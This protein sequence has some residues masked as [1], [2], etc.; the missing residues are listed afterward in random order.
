M[1]GHIPAFK[2]R[3]RRQLWCLFVHHVADRVDVRCAGLEEFVHHDAVRVGFDVCSVKVQ[4]II[5]PPP[6]RRKDLLDIQGETLGGKA[7]P[8]GH[9]LHA[10]QFNV[11]VKVNVRVLHRLL[12]GR[13]GVF[14]KRPQRPVAVHDDMYLCASFGRD[15]GQLHADVPGPDEATRCGS[16]SMSRKSRLVLIS[17]W[18][19]MLGRTG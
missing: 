12:Q 3:H 7:Q 2:P 15:V 11:F 6:H 17:S 10:G 9:L 5:R 1:L 14:G 18:P 19:R 13:H 16:W 8:V 4:L